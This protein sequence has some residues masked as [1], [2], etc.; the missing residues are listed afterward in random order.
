MVFVICL[1][2][3]FLLFLKDLNEIIIIDFFYS[4][5]FIGVIIIIVNDW[6][7]N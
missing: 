1:Y 2:F 6:G 5:V 3:Y 7:R 4:L